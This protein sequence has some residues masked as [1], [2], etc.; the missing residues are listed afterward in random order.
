MMDGHLERALIEV[1][2]AMAEFEQAKYAGD[3]G[4]GGEK[5]DFVEKGLRAVRFNLESILRLR[6]ESGSVSAMQACA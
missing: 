6:E 2:Y 5:G 3:P 4:T 1:F